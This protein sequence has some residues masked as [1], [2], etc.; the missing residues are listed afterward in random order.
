MKRLSITRQILRLKKLG[1]LAFFFLILYF[2][3]YAI[4]GGKE[5]LLLWY[6]AIIPTLLPFIILSNTLIAIQ[7][8][9]Y[10]TYLFYPLYKIFPKLLDC[11]APLF[12]I[13][14]FC[15]YPMGAKMI[16]DFI[17]TKQM[18]RTQGYFFLCIC[19]HA[20]P[21]FLIGY[22]ATAVLKNTISIPLLLFCIYA[23]V[24]LFLLLGFLLKPSF[25]WKA[26]THCSKIKKP[27]HNEMDV[28]A[29]SFTVILKVG[30][31]IMMFSIL[32]QLL[33]LLPLH[34]QWF[35]SFLIGISEITTGIRHIYNLNIP[36]KEK[37]AFISGLATFGGISSIAQSK[38]VLIH[39]KLSI[40]P[41]I[42]AKT[43]FS[44][45]TIFLI[46]LLS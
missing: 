1:F 45:S 30:G 10:F 32:S 17:A 12:T 6:D 4:K 43:I 31:Y 15:G 26:N 37:T 39:S 18:T 38:S 3:Q 5:G 19:N 21:M 24:F 16:D 11:L 23:P 35:K 8:M 29:D 25:F 28:M 36:L 27:F 40:I 2:P 46:V 22:V 34:N 14:F 9:E 13:G 44:I 41:Y 20:S 33:F 42:I 7:G